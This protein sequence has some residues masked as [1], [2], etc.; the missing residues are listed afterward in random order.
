D[1]R[2][3]LV[4]L[5]P[6]GLEAALV[7]VPGVTDAGVLDGVRG[8]VA[9]HPHRLLG[10]VR[11]ERPAHGGGVVVVEGEHEIGC[12][13]LGVVH[14]PRPVRLR[15]PA[16][17]AGQG[18][19]ARSERVVHLPAGGACRGDVD[20]IAEARL[21]ER[22]AHG[23]LDHRGPADVAGADGQDPVGH[24]PSSSVWSSVCPSDCS[25]VVSS[26][27]AYSGWRSIHLRT[28][29]LVGRTCIPSARM[30][31]RAKR[32]A[33]EPMPAPERSG[34]TT[35]ERRSR[36]RAPRSPTGGSSSSWARTAT[37]SAPSSAS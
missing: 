30:P 25:P 26:R 21:L 6:G 4:D 28:N 23:V 7:A 12:L 5:L 27:S 36:T 22:L 17:A 35:V 1:P 2:E 3:G 20:A 32:A 10:P 13:Q 16:W 14:L 37:T 29:Q 15:A 11:A 9:H 8:E 34:A 19:G 31:S 24:R 18:G 33:A